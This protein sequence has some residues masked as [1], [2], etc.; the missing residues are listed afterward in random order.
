MYNRYGH[1]MYAVGALV[2]NSLSLL[3]DAAAMSVDVFSYLV[4]LVVSSK[5]KI[6]SSLLYAYTYI[7]ILQYFYFFFITHSFPYIIHVNSISTT[8]NRVI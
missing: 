8:L 4:G 7:C 2:S 6:L 5:I 1:H 3:G